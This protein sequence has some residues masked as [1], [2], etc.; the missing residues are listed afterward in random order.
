MMSAVQADYELQL[1]HFSDIDGGGDLTTAPKYFS[2]LV[3]KFRSDYANTLLLS[4]GDNWIPGPEYTVSSDS[5]FEAVLGVPGVGRVNAAFCNALGV[6]ASAVGN[7][8]CDKDMGDFASI[9]SSETDAGKTWVG[10]QFPYLSANLDFSTDTNTQPLIK[11]DGAESTAQYGGFAKSS[12]ITVNGEKIGIVGATTPLLKEISHAANIGVSPADANSRADLAAV[13][14]PVVDALTAAGVNKIILLSHLQQ[15]VVEKELAPLLKDVDII[16]AGGSNSLL[17][18]DNDRVTAGST[19]DGTYP[20]SYS[21]ASNDPIL[22]VNTEGDYAYVGRLVVTFDNDGKIRTDMLDSAVNGVVLT[23]DASLTA[24]GLT[25]A[26]AIPEVVA[27]S[28]ALKVALDAKVGTVVGRTSVYLNGV[29]ASVRTEETNFGQLSAGADLY[30]AQAFDNTVTFHIKNGGGMRAAIGECNVPAGSITTVCLP[31]QAVAGIK[32]LGDISQLDLETSLRFNNE[33]ALITVTVTELKQILEHSVAGVAPGSTPG[34][35]GHVS[36]L[37]FSYDAT[38]TAQT[39]DTTS[40]PV[41]SG[42]G[43]RI[44]NVKLMDDNGAAAGGKSVILVQDGQ[45]VAGM[46]AVKFRISGSNYIVDGG[47][48]YPFPNSAEANK[49]LLTAQTGEDGKFT[50]APY[51]TEQDAF[52]EYMTMMYPVDGPISFDM[53]DTPAAKDEVMQ[54]LASVTTDTVIYTR[55]QL[56]HFSDIDGGGDLTTAPKYFSALVK[57]FRSDYANTVLLSSGDNWIPGPEY[58][59]SKESSFEGVLGVPGEGRVNAAFCNALGVQ[60]SAVGN[61]ECDRGMGEFTSIISSETDAGKTWVGAQ[62]PYLS[63]NLDFST[64]TNTQPLIKTDGAES[65]AQYGGFAKSSV[66]TVNGEKI[67]VVG[68]TTPLLQQISSAPNVGVSPA[69]VNSR[70]DLAA[71]IQPTVDALTATGIN[72]IILIAHMQQ[73]VVE[74]EL[75][76]LL[77]DVDIIVAGGSNSLLADDNDRVTAG[78]TKDGTYPLSYSSASND[79]ILVVNTEGDYEYVGRLVVTFDNDGKIRTDMLDSAVNGVVLADDASLTA[80]SITLADAIPEVV[81]LS[82]ALKVALDAKVGNVA[83]K[84]SVYLNGER[85]SVRTEETNFALLSARADL[86]MSQAHDANVVMHIKNG[87]GLRASVGRCILPSGTNDPTKVVCSATSAVPGVKGAGEISQL[88]IETALRF[89]NEITLVTVT[90]KELKQILEHSVAGVAPGSTP[91]QFGHVAGLRF[92]YNASMTA[93]TVYSP[94]DGSEFKPYV[95]A[96]GYRVRSVV[97]LDNNGALEGGSEIVLV[98]DGVI[99]KG[100]ENTRFRISASNY[101]VGG[102]DT[103]PFPTANVDKVLL[104]SVAG[105]KGRFQYAAYGTEQDAL[106]EY[107]GNHYPVAEDAAMYTVADMPASQ[108]THIQNLDAVVEDTVIVTDNFPV[109][110]TMVPLPPIP[111]PVVN[112]QVPPPV[113]SGAKNDNDN[114]DLI[115]GFGVPSLV[116]LVCLLV[117]VVVNKPSAAKTVPYNSA[118]EPTA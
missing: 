81:A 18:D 33:I 118:T 87:G 9:I 54:N 71:A 20:L 41:V 42:A 106:Y 95:T 45:I 75:A 69:D 43:E 77:K 57:K 17:A 49:V 82:D 64:D 74:K 89:N 88:D 24:H 10:A 91:G 105:P 90:V 70:A 8:E 28:D 85:G 46:E 101:I 72:K 83:G 36:G 99:A 86:E 78:S 109:E 97:L 12:V 40:H 30:A 37:R 32:N 93:Q 79:P 52:A 117:F 96:P 11:T 116:L 111:E 73:L 104:S 102:G 5:S 103:Y 108:D 59:V 50:F 31:T 56:L 65:T 44:R 29:R 61:H 115:I 19:K 16:V 63:A 66:I 68:A 62:F 92:S 26:D 39:V 67:G 14:Q 60:A 107:L 2:A 48:G 94:P 34:Q 84:T 13:I 21:S 76:P 100:M 51:G 35:F 55:L 23:D 80:H 98:K 27:L 58:S 4:S 114:E 113:S 6:Q 47:D 3:K 22:V 1:L 7:H 110:P 53:I 25:L 38:K 112:V 15:I